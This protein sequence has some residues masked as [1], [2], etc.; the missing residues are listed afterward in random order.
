MSGWVMLQFGLC[1]IVFF[2]LLRTTAPYGRHHAPGWGPSLPNRRAWFLME[3]PALAVPALVLIAGLTEA[4]PVALVPWLMW[5]IHYGYR[6][7]VFPALMRPS[8]KNFP[9]LLV[10]FAVAFNILN[11]YNNG[12]ALLNNASSG[13]ALIS[14]HFLFGSLIFGLGFWIHVQSDTIIRNLRQ[15]GSKGYS[16][17]RGFWF[18]RLSSPHYLGEIIQWTGWA[19]LTWSWAG[20]AF[21]LFTACNLVP[22]AIANHR[23]YL[24]T[25]EHYPLKRKRIIP[26]VY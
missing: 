23:W 5:S 22:R 10:L 3:L 15:D 2:S 13:V 17:P 14:P 24:K 12:Q 7:F 18:E 11:G 16:I 4:V 21:A 6:T 19:I 20:L 1:P 25:F 26:G 9:L 8:G